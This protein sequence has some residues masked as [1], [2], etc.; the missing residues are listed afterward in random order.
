MRLGSLRMNMQSPSPDPRGNNKWAA[1]V[2][3]MAFVHPDR[4][5]PRRVRLQT[6]IR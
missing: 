4:I 5:N 1:G 2:M 6:G 3:V